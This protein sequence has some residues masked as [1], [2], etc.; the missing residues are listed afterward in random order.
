MRFGILLITLLML[1]LMPA[2]AGSLEPGYVPDE[3]VSTP[4]YGRQDNARRDA[5]LDFIAG[6]RPHHEGAL[7]MSEAYLKDPGAT[8]A[9]LKQ[10]AR[11]IYHNQ[12]FEI[13]MLNEVERFVERPV[14]NEKRRIATK[15]LGQVKKFY[16]MPVP[17]PW[18]KQEGAAAGASARDVQFAKGMIIHHQAALKM[19]DDYL[20]NPVAKNG[21]L[22]KMCLDILLDQEQEIRFMNKIIALYPGNPADIAVDHSMIHG[23]DHMNHEAAPAPHVEAQPLTEN[24]MPHMDHENMHMDETEQ[25]PAAGSDGWFNILRKLKKEPQP[26]EA[27]PQAQ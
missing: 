21:Y 12:L 6:M 5:D 2:F 11:G 22:E 14:T 8:N 27:P 15:G 17:G 10:L 25:E 20:R 13:E 19:A 3:R 16:R 18:D 9:Q 23:M 7:T 4:W 1:P 24:D 26:V